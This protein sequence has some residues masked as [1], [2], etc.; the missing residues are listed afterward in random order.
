MLKRLKI[1]LT[2]K[3]ISRKT[4]NR[5][6][7]LYRDFV[8]GEIEQGM[9]LVEGY[10]EL[11][12]KIYTLPSENI[13]Q[14]PYPAE[15]QNWLYSFIWLRDLHAFGTSTARL[16]A[17]QMILAWA[18]T[19]PKDDTASH[20]AIIGQRIAHILG[21]YEFCLM[22]ASTEQ[23]SIIM[24]MLIRDG[25]SLTQHL[26]LRTHTWENLSILRGIL[27]SF[28]AF[29]EKK[30][31]YTSFQHYLPIE[32]EKLIH[33]DG[34]VKERS[35]EAQFQTV[36]EL[37][38][39]SAMLTSIG[40]AQPLYLHEIIKKTCA[41]LRALCHRD[42]ALALFNNSN[43]RTSKELNHLLDRAERYR[44]ISP[45]LPNG[46]FVRL[47]SGQALLLVD[48]APPPNLDKRAHASTLSFEFSYH[49]QRIFVN[50]GTSPFEPFK[51]LLRESVAHNV[52]TLNGQSSSAFNDKGEII[53]QPT[54]VTAEHYHQQGKDWLECY[55]NGYYPAYRATWHRQFYLAKEGTEFKGDD[56]IQAETPLSSIMRFYLHPT[57]KVQQED[58]DIILSMADKSLWRFRAQGGQMTIEDALYFGRGFKEK[59]KQ[60]VIRTS[61][62]PQ[63]KKTDSQSSQQFF[64]CR[65]SWL[66]ERVPE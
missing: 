64:Y 18:T 45:I 9:R 29:H 39:I 10:F 5:P 37:V 38:S 50:S 42:G 19:M 35:P 58:D 2:Q 6:T 33:P 63:E 40:V 15:I 65:I 1:F 55:Q 16:K 57:I 49:T 66:L 51:S 54:D 46:Q 56:I 60:I 32:L 59:N 41:V 23:Q 28:M 31:L 25:L 27:A 3:T 61:L 20:P 14:G 52:I 36:H 11:Y 47:T 62:Y 24:K 7:F 34:T 53:H 22:T 21:H 8:L 48:V 4:L 43:E 26:P 12:Q 44:I 17:R 13:W 30:G